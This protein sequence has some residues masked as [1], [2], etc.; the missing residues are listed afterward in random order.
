V[1]A[2]CGGQ[3]S[4]F[5]EQSL[6]GLLRRRRQGHPFSLEYAAV[7]EGGGV[8][9]RESQMFLDGANH[10]YGSDA[11]RTAAIAFDRKLDLNHPSAP[12]WLRA[13]E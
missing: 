12:A 3:P 5:G 9:E 8:V 13:R 7:D 11:Q 10:R 2:R 1:K 6:C 4:E